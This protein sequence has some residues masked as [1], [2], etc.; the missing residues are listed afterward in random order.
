MP[1]TVSHIAAALPFRSRRLV[2][3]AVVAGTIAPDLPKYFF[4][5]PG[6]GASHTWVEAFGVGV[7]AA[8]FLLWLFDRFLKYALQA[9]APVRLHALNQVN[10]ASISLRRPAQFVGILFSIC[11]GILTHVFLDSLTHHGTWITRAFPAME[12]QCPFDAAR[13]YLAPMEWIDVLQYALTFLGLGVL[14]YALAIFLRNQ[15]PE[16][17]LGNARFSPTA[18]VVLICLMAS[19]ALGCG[20]I[21]MHVHSVVHWRVP[22][23]TGLAALFI[24]A[25]SVAFVQLLILGIFLRL[26]PERSAAASA[27]A[28]ALTSAEV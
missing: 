10:C 5:N 6:N 11:L 21:R 3:S 2:F 8:V 24:T 14:A 27:R 15:I 1:L 16:Q 20:W 22:P 18:R 25:V 4:L 7:P 13:T 9:L 23:P 12:T 19:I 17:F 28:E 26:L